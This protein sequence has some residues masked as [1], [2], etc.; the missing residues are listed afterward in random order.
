MA[1]EST[2]EQLQQQEHWQFVRKFYSKFFAI[3]C[4]LGHSQAKEDGVEKA[5]KI[6]IKNVLKVLNFEGEEG[7]KGKVGREEKRREEIKQSAI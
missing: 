7:A 6:S 2:K 5:A 1:I 4:R 3:C